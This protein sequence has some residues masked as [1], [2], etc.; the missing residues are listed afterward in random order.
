MRM[1]FI[2]LILCFFCPGVVC[3]DNKL[4]FPEEINPKGNPKRAEW[5]SEGTF[6]M[7]THYLITPQ[8]A[9][10]AEKNSDFN[11]TLDNFDLQLYMEQF[12]RTKADWLIFTIG[13]NTGYWNSSNKVLDAVLPGRTPKRDLVLEIAKAVKQRGKHFIA[14]LPGDTHHVDDGRGYYKTWEE[15]LLDYSLKFGEYCDGWWID[16]CDPAVLKGI[17]GDNWAKAMRAGNPNSAIAMSMGPYLDGNL[18]KVSRTVDYFP[19]EVHYVE[20][21]FIRTDPLFRDVFLNDK[22]R[23]RVNRQTPLFFVPKEQLIDGTLL[24]ALVPL[25]WTFNPAILSEWVNFPEKDMITLAHSFSKVGGA[26]T[27]NVPVENSGKIPDGSLNK[28]IAI[29]K[30]YSDNTE[31]PLDMT[32]LERTKEEEGGAGENPNPA[33]KAFGK[34]S[35]LLSLDGTT[36]ALPSAWV[37]HAWKGNDGDDTTAAI[38]AYHWAWTY[39]LDL[40]EIMP[41]KK[42]TLLFANN[43]WSTD[44]AINT[45]KDGSQWNGLKHIK[46]SDNEKFFS[47]EMDDNIRYITVQSFQPDGEGQIGVQMAVA[48]LQVFQQNDPQSSSS[49]KLPV[50]KPGW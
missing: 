45:S 39:W 34:P 15:V 28:L 26:V 9:T 17:K 41:V 46:N 12:D 16:G 42:I 31:Y 22:G 3:C 8:G 25:D 1:L 5:M 13:Q 40:E 11:R 4:E 10:D 47:I 32:V 38:A 33:N 20:D 18:K 6:G 35:K 14:Y 30:S 49:D 23:V 19:G 37:A 50:M 21:A 44:F 27:F 48:E 43:G 24:H 36:E 2:L 7:M 29:G